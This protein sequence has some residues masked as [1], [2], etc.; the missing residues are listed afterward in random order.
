MAR[1][2]A[3]GLIPALMVLLIGGAA[4]GQGMQTFKTE[5]AT[6]PGRR[7]PSRP[8]P[9]HLI[10]GSRRVPLNGGIFF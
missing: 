5:K 1:L 9:A 8:R 6:L 3:Y 2:I 4:L 7:H 10:R